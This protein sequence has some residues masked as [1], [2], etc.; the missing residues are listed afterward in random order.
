M[1][2]RSSSRFAAW[3]FAS[4]L[5]LGFMIPAPVSAAPADDIKEATK[6]YQSGK[7]DQALTKVN[8]ALAQQPK[9]AQGRFIKGLIYT[10]QKRT[11]DAIQIFTGLTEDYPELPEPYNNLAVLYAGQG[12]YDKAKAALE[13]AIHTH[14][15]YATAYENLGDVYAQLARRSY[16]KALQLDKNN[17]GVQTKMAMVK[18][19]FSAPKSASTEPVKSAPVAVATAP[20]KAEPAKVTPPAKAEPVKADPA[21]AEPAKSEPAKPAAAGNAD[22]QVAAAVA[23]WAKAWAAKDVAGYLAAY[24]SDFTPPDGM[25]RAAWEAQR[26]ERIERAKSISV[27]AKIVKTAFAGNVATVT[28]RQAYRSDTVKSDNTKTL[29]M[30]RSGD[31]WFIRSE[32]AAK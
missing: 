32:R 18:D 4:A 28:I 26:K 19:L 24:A 11:A 31:K 2:L 8:G 22:A 10:E 21:K 16:D 23:A 17:P 20:V 29:V 6:L 15:A 14:P 9:D 25:T 30:V 7:F 3:A 12:N 13:L 1:P 5:S 27:E